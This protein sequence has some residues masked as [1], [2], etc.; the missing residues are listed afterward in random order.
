MNNE[1]L[2]VR[3]I[4]LNKA[5][6]VVAI[7]VWMDM[8]M[9]YFALQHHMVKYPDTWR[10]KELSFTVGPLLNI[11][12]LDIIPALI[13]GGI[14]NTAIYITVVKKIKTEFV[15]GII[16]GA[17]MLAFLSNARIAFLT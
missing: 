17:I 14:I 11:L 16:F 13:I 3:S 15:Y 9:T 4:L 5:L 1:T 7:L 6:V 8:G 10:Q 12:K 2:I